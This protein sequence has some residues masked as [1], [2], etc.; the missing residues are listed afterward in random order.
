[1]LIRELQPRTYN[2]LSVVRSVAAETVRASAD[3]ENFRERFASRID[4]LAQVQRHP[5]I[6]VAG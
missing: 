6:D 1:M 3:I 5:R 2:K 4:A